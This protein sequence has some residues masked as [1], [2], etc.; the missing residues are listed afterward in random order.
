MSRGEPTHQQADRGGHER[1]QA[2]PPHV[3]RSRRAA[4]FATGFLLAAPFYLLLVDTL[5]VPE[6]W[7][8]LA[9]VLI[10]AAA[11]E[12]GREQG[13]AE[14]SVSPRWLLR[15]WRAVARVPGDLVRLA[16]AAFAAL[17]PWRRPPSGGLRAIRFDYGKDED[18]RDVGRRSLAEALGS[19]SPNTIVIG[20]DA[21]REVLLVH[22]LC[23]H[24]DA[25]EID[26]LSVR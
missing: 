8:G 4:G 5:D 23:R 10:A 9:V 22:Q 19:L 2:P 13:F 25:E 21:A 1:S 14:A 18:P 7:A 24:G 17:P 16:A 26:V 6:L 15:S 20:T 3:P 11:F 12:T